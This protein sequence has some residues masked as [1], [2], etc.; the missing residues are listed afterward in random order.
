MA[1]RSWR[2]RSS[3]R[4]LASAY[5]PASNNIENESNGINGGNWRRKLWQRISVI[6]RRNGG[7][8]AA[9]SNNRWRGYQLAAAAKSKA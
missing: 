7:E 1:Y 5:T 4:K 8:M 3:Y 2:P 6:W 9:A